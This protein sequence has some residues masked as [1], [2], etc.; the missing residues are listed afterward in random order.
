MYKLR[1]FKNGFY[2]IENEK[3]AFT[4]TLNEVLK[5]AH[6]MGLAEDDLVEAF[7]SF[8][9]SGYDWAEFGRY[10]RYTISGFDRF[11]QTA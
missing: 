9:D 7:M 5:V 11:R 1:D 4:G 6:V 8:T 10:G 2:K 3:K